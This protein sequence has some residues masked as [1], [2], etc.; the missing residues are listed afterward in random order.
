VNHGPDARGHARRRVRAPSVRS[1][2]RSS[3]RDVRPGKVTAP[4]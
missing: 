1:I 3:G 4:R 2:V